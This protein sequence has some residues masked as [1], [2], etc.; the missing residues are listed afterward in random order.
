MGITNNVT[1]EEI[2]ALKASYL[3]DLRAGEISQ[4]MY[5]TITK[6]LDSLKSQAA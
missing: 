1:L 6:W 5:E 2:D 3:V 4:S